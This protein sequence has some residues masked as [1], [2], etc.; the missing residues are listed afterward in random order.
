MRNLLIDKN[1]RERIS[2]GSGIVITELINFPRKRRTEKRIIISRHTTMVIDH[3]FIFH[4]PPNIN[5]FNY[6]GMGHPLRIENNK[7]K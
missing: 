5:V 1:D 4:I 3:K 2:R 7:S 6:Q